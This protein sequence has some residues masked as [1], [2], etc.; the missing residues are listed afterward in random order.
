M[1]KFDFVHSLGQF[2]TQIHNAN[3]FCL[4]FFILLYFFLLNFVSHMN[5]IVPLI[6][7]LYSK[8]IALTKTE[9]ICSKTMY[10]WKKI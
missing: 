10:K 5:I 8:D 9:K 2:S 1:K 4:I 6:N 7:F 3:Y